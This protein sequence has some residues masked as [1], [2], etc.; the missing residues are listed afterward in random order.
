MFPGNAAFAAE[1]PIKLKVL[2]AWGQDYAFVK[3]WLLKWIERV[4]ERSEGRIEPSWVGPEAVPVMAQ[5]KPLSEGLFDVL[6]THPTYHMGEISVANGQDAFQGSARERRIFGFLEFFDKGYKQVNLKVLGLSNGDVGFHFMLKKPLDSADFSGF[7]I[8]S[9]ALYDPTIEALGGS[10]VQSRPA[11]VYTMLE[12]G[13]VDGACWPTIGALDYKWYEVTKFLVRPAFG[14]ITEMLF[15]NLDKWNSLP[16]DVKKLL[17]EVTMEVEVEGYKD[18]TDYNEY[19]EKELVKLG[20]KLNILPPE[21]GKRLQKTFFQQVLKEIV[22][23]HSG[24]FASPMKEMSE[25]FIKRTGQ[26]W[27]LE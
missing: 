14:N 4:K 11:D 5:L 16:E 17:T 27:L 20:M 23:K 2:S 13:V 22:M 9:T 19:E 3:V 26:T 6:Y 8:R 21:D 24:E 10:T 15:I 7:K 12:R 18:L 25:T 1:K